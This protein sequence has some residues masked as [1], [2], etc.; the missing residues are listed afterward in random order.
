MLR[1]GRVL[2]GTEQAGAF[3]HVFDC[4]CWCIIHY[5]IQ[6]VINSCG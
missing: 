5:Y 2:W 6:T 1:M 4:W 3:C